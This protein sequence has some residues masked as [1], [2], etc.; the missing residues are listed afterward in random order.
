MIIEACK[1]T[2]CLFEA[3]G[4]I[5]C[6]QSV[7]TVNRTLLTTVAARYV[8]HGRS[9]VGNCRGVLNTRSSTTSSWSA[10]GRSRVDRELAAIPQ[11]RPDKIFEHSY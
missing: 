8:L 7:Y 9:G 4:Q 6:T 11:E 2:V 10:G 3:Y 5:R 1:W